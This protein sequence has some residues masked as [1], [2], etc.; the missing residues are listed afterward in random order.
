M[1]WHPDIPDI[2][3]SKPEKIAR[4]ER[5]DRSFLDSLPG[6][7]VEELV[8][9]AALSIAKTYKKEKQKPSCTECCEVVSVAM[10]VTGSAIGGQVGLALIADADSAAE[11]ACRSLFPETK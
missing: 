6:T 5:M 2:P 11:N 4:L 10:T 9:D 7:E 8:Q 1:S 3:I